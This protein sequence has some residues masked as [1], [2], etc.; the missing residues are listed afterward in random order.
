MVKLNTELPK[1]QLI[2]NGYSQLSPQVPHIFL[3]FVENI[4]LFCR[5]F[6]QKLTI[7]NERLNNEPQ[8]EE[9]YDIIPPSVSVMT[10]SFIQNRIS[11]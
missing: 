3:F 6:E 11:L 8:I 10:L 5:K 4:I 1:L 7:N 2:E 9:T